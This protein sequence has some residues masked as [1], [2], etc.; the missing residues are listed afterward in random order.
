[1]KDEREDWPDLLVT[2]ITMGCLWHAFGFLGMVGLMGLAGEV[3]RQCK[4]SD[5]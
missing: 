5:K 1:M 3:I 4:N 2:L